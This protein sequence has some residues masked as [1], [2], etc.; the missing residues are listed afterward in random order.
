VEDTEPK[1][2]PWRVKRFI[3]GGVEPEKIPYGFVCDH[4]W[5]EYRS[6]WYRCTR[7][8]WVKRV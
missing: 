1:V 5:G 2:S 3:D 7:C 6:E 4:S 8:S